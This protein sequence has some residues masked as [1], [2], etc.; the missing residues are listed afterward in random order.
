[1]ASGLS[2]VVAA[3]ACLTVFAGPAAAADN[4]ANKGREALRDCLRKLPLDR[5]GDERAIAACLEQGQRA[6]ESEDKRQG[7]IDYLR[8]LDELDR[9]IERTT[10]GSRR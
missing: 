6:A 5:L 2:W 3:V 4:A 9:M 8:K 7:Q 1:M 10:R